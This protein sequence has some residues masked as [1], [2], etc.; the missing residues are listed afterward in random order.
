MAQA[1]TNKLKYLVGSGGIDL[2]ASDIR[3][4]LLKTCA[5][6]ATSTPDIN[7]VT[8]MEAHADFAE[9]TGATGYARV[10]L[11]SKTVTE[12]DTNDRANV[13]AADVS[14]GA[15][16]AGGTIVGAFIFQQVTTDTDS[17]VLA[18]YDLPSTA[19]S[20]GTVTVTVADWLRIT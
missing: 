16:A 10:A 3:M 7:F 17:P 8:D 2:D 13:D 15:L 1:T 18:I 20:G 6:V 19:T 5:N 14:F 9:L 4:G 11:T 12:D